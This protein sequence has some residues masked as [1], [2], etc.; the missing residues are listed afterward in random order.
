M[1]IPLSSFNHSR[2][3][4]VVTNRMTKIITYKRTLLLTIIAILGIINYI[5]SSQYNNNIKIDDQSQ[6]DAKIIINHPNETSSSLYLYPPHEAHPFVID[7]NPT[8]KNNDFRTTNN[9]QP[10]VIEFYDP[11]CGACQAFKYNYIEIAKKIQQQKPHVQFYGVSCQVYK[12]TCDEF[13]VKR[14]PKI[15]AFPNGGSVRK[16][17][18]IEVPK[19]TGTIYFVSARLMKAL[20]TKEEIER[21]GRVDDASSKFAAGR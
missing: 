7:Y 15:V 18:G 3:H 4:K 11:K 12:S 20:R 2:R 17:D 1:L 10:K 5:R 14:F 16:E 9:P 8:T 19:G 6:H 13:G 21:D